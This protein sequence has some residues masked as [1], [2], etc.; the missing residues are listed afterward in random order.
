MPNGE[1]KREKNDFISIFR[2]FQIF[3]TLDKDKVKDNLL[4]SHLF[5]FN[6]NIDNFEVIQQI[7]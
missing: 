1:K 5:K 7:K 4:F 2:L 3:N 6:F